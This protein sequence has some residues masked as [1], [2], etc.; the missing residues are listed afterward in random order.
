[1][2]HGLCGFLLPEEVFCQ[3]QKRQGEG[4]ESP[5]LLLRTLEAFPV[6]TLL[7]CA[8]PVSLTLLRNLLMIPIG[9]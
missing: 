6:Q 5:H 1:M 9:S 7:P 4:A 2:F 8:S 3:Y